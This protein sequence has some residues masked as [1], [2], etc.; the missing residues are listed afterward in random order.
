MKKIKYLAF[1]CVLGFSSF[2][3]SA[4]E[5]DPKNDVDPQE[6]VEQLENRLQEIWQMDLND[7][8]KEEKTVLKMEVKDIKKELKQAGLDSKVSI[9][10]GAIIIILLLLILL[11]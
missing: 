11:T 2:T 5:T 4:N 9:S 3:S 10:V 8:D 7:M 1:V 6:K